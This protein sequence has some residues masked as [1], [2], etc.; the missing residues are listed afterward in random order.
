MEA[1]ANIK[2]CHSTFG[3]FLIQS[4]GAS[5]PTLSGFLDV[6]VQLPIGSTQIEKL[7]GA[8]TYLP[9]IQKLFHQIQTDSGAKAKQELQ[10][11]MNEG[12]FIISSP[13]VPIGTMV[14]DDTVMKVRVASGEEYSVRQLEDI[15][16]RLVRSFEL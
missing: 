10:H 9:V 7:R 2:Q 3:N 11:I 13:D 8:I 1:I 6:Y 16:N 5:F 15:R 12:V 14:D 4:F